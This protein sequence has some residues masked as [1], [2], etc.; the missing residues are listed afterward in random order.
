MPSMRRVIITA[1]GA[2]LTALA[3]SVV[4]TADLFGARTTSPFARSVAAVFDHPRPYPGYTWTREG[5]A[6]PGGEL[7]AIGGPDHCGWQSATMLIIGWPPGIVSTSRAQ[8]RQYIRDPR[9]DIRRE[10]QLKLVKNA[11]LPADARPTGYRYG[12]IE[13]YLSP[14][15]QDE[16]IYVVSPT[17]VERW[18]RSDP[19]TLCA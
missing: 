12:L 19:M 14:S 15:D 16:A 4:W 6:V 2:V 13:L 5:R 1:A 9:G 11:R 8:A 3:V 18:P 17:D 7:G 10:L